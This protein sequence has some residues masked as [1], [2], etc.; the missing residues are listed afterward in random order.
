ML[1]PGIVAD[2]QGDNCH[3][4]Q[5]SKDSPDHHEHTWQVSPGHEIPKAQRGKRDETKV[6]VVLDGVIPGGDEKRG[7]R[8]P[9][10]A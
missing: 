10:N 2:E 5:L 1:F 7:A 9:T 8:L 6:Q 3:K 4:A